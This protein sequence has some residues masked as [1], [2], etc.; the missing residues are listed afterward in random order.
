MS[1]GNVF[2][3]LWLV[4][5]HLD[6]PGVYPVAKLVDTPVSKLEKRDCPEAIELYYKKQLAEAWGSEVPCNTP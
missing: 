6:L 1:P 4:E 5:S 2:D 3:V